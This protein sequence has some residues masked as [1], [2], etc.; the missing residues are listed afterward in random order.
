MSR[1][2][3]VKV[4][5]YLTAGSGKELAQSSLEVY[6]DLLGDLPYDVLA[7]AAK[8]VLLTH[9]WAT[10]PSV[11]ELREAAALTSRGEVV[12]LSAAEAW[13][14]AWRTAG[15]TDPEVDGSFARAAKGLP[16]IVVR[17]I[18]TFGLNALCY[19]KEPVGVLRAQF[20][21]MFE[22]LAARE[23]ENALLP[24]ATRQAIEAQSPSPAEPVRALLSG[25]GRP[26]DEEAA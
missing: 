17:A 25:I 1:Q 7:V 15:C 16:T 19:G 24:A 6:F 3:F 9:P 26:P 8:R 21:K 12:P 5:A 13:A 4:M 10:F 23:H 14:L 2:E 20:M 11:A 22:Q 18:S